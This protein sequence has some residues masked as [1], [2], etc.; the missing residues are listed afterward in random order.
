MDAR[1]A[2]IRAKVALLA[3]VDRDR[4]VFGAATHDFTFGPPLS[5]TELAG[6]E[7]PCGSMP[8]AFRKLLVQLGASGAGPYYGLVPPHAEPHPELGAAVVLCEQGCGG[9]SL[10]ALPSGAVWSDWTREGGTLEPEAPDVLTWYEQWLDRALIEWAERAA[11]RL[12]IDGP[13]DPAELE[14]VMEA[15]EPLLRAAPG[16]PQLQRTLGYLHLREKRFADAAAA[17]DEAAK[18]GGDEPDARRYLDHA[19][20]ALVRGTYDGA[21]E[22]AEK[23]LACEGLWYSTR[24]E[25]RDVL[26][27][28]LGAA[29]RADEALAVLD[30][31]AAECFF[32]FSLHHRL[33]RERL[34]RGDVAGAGAALERA[35]AMPN[36]LGPGASS[37]ERLAASFEPIIRELE[38][39]R[40][41]AEAE[42]L[43]ALADRIRNAN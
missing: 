19:R 36:I 22:R 39:A 20:L 8:T 4:Q 6:L 10:L 23:G 25:L 15:F 26:E 16:N 42:L 17:F 34:A 33:A 2:T 11:P 38:G 21:I 30:G 29:G 13:E 18:A 35:A 7:A 41:P 32:S 37:D 24:D 3:A 14:A 9:R 28:A 12:A 1:L 27:R 40:R 5:E 43:A 31:R